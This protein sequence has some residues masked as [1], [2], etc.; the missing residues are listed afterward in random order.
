MQANAQGHAALRRV[1][2]IDG[3]GIKGALP[4]SFLATVEDAIGDSVANYFDLIVGTSTGGIVALGLGLGL[5][6]ERLLS[7]YE[8]HGPTVFYAGTLLRRICSLW[9]A[10]YNP[11][12]LRQALETE[13]GD[14][15]LG[16]SRTRLVIPSLNLETGRVYIYKTSHHPRLE[17]DYK[18]RAVDVALATAAAPTY[19]PAHRTAAGI[20]LVDGGMWANNPVG[21]AVVEAVGMLG[22]AADSLNVLS[23]GC[24]TTPLHLGRG[25]QGAPG[26]GYWG[27]RIVDVFMAAQSSGSL[28][29]AYVF[30]GHDNVVRISP[31]VG[32]GRFS[33]DSVKEIPT[34]RGLGD[35]EAR[36]WLPRLRPMFFADHAEPFEPYHRL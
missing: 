27:S 19:F 34:L 31:V 6:A 17:R 16:E 1:L 22:W 30:A 23:L 35:S 21:I 14:R 18:V 5:S 13:L 11:A 15:K 4:A 10:K 8:T 9:R 2:S 36:D 3:G 28:G 12:P 26:L 32:K 33:L 29:T 25:H 7:F 24:G 20:P